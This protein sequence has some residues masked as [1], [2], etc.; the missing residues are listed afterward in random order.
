M[1][2][3][4]VKQHVCST[5]KS[6]KKSV[7]SQCKRQQ[8]RKHDLRISDTKQCTQNTIC[9]IEN[10]SHSPV[11]CRGTISVH[12]YCT[13]LPQNTIKGIK[14]HSGRA[15]NNVHE[16][17]ILYLDHVLFYSLYNTQMRLYR[18]LQIILYNLEICLKKIHIKY[19]E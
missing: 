1:N 12:F 4:W 3:Y 19:P 17:N 7:F 13:F 18:S 16:Q 8:S 6:G 9:T 2:I 14:Y 11:G 5:R 10:C 15:L